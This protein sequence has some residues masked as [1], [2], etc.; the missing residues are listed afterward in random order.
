MEGRW[1]D[2]RT[3]QDIMAEQSTS[4]YQRSPCC[5]AAGAESD[6][7]IAEFKFSRV[8]PSSPDRIQGESWCYDHYGYYMAT[9]WPLYGHTDYETYGHI[10]DSI[11]GDQHNMLQ[12]TQYRTK[13]WG[14]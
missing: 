6:L 14:R 1:T 4:Y 9:T 10:S 12:V 13:T 3:D 5:L 7:D 2:C 8:S 11:S